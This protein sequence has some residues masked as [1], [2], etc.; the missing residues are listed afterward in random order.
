MYLQDSQERRYC[1]GTFPLH[2]LWERFGMVRIDSFVQLLPAGREM[3]EMQSEAVL[4]VST[5]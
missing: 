1:E 4:A 3:Q 2:E 5:D